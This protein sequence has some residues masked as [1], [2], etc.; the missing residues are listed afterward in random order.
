[1]ALSLIRCSLEGRPSGAGAD[2]LTYLC[3]ATMAAHAPY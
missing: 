1:M 2:M 3:H